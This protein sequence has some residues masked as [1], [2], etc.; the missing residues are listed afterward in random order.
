MHLHSSYL[1]W[2]EREDE[3]DEED[4]RYL[5]L[6]DEELAR[7]TKMHVRRGDDEVNGEMRWRNSRA[8]ASSLLWRLSLRATTP[9]LPLP[10]SLPPIST[11]I[12]R[13]IAMAVCGC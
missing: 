11:D 9:P 4:E 6:G 5:R 7:K 1:Q 13:C 8:A 3:E 10:L 12:I 2:S